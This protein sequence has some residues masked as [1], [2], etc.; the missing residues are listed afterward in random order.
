MSDTS[1]Q[2]LKR[3]FWWLGGA[4]VV[5]RAIG[6]VAS[7]VVLEKFTGVDMGVATVV[8]T[9]MVI[10]ETLSGLGVG[11]H[12]MQARELEEKRV[13]SLFWFATGMG[14]VLA[15]VTVA[16][17]PLLAWVYDQ[18]EL[19]PLLAAASLKLV[20]VGVAL[21]PL[22]LALRTLRF[23]VQSIS[24]T[25]AAFF[26]AGTTIGLALLGYGAWALVW[27]GTVRGAV[28]CATVL[29]I[30]P[31]RVRFAFAWR[32][33][34]E[35]VR[36]GAGLA[37]ASLV[38]FT[39][40]NVER[41]IV[42]AILG[43]GVLGVY[44]AASDFAMVPVSAVLAVVIR[45]G[46]PVLARAAHR[47]GDLVS[48]YYRN[49]QYTLYL[50]GPILV[51]FFFAADPILRVLGEG[52][53]ATGLPWMRVLC[54]AALLRAVSEGFAQLYVA[55]G[56]PDMVLRDNLLRLL[57]VVVLMGGGLLAFGDRLG[58]MVIAIAWVVAQLVG[59]FWQWSFARA[60][61]SIRLADYARTLMRPGAAIAF[62]ATSMALLRWMG[63]FEWT[64]L[65]SAVARVA[66]EV[67]AMAAATLALYLGFVS[68]VLGHRLRDLIPK[69]ASA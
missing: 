22:H 33:I 63:A 49:A 11:S 65:S 59:L 14:V 66:V 17:S 9:A 54:A 26:E 47:S 15:L 12:I 39:S 38:D 32:D 1:A 50:V 5:M 29:M 24:E 55:A 36:F 27:S 41:L 2:D 40:K 6:L 3:G 48:A 56:R 4:S 16:V 30:A 69:G 7:G 35:S 31:V 42:P 61:S 53:W 51:F 45:A 60:V 52:R 44:R 18:P 46:F 25:T 19:V 21:V 64:V 28:L 58:A 62:A 10:V 57:A 20:F 68:V 43:L 67:A 8:W 34:G 37:V 13:L 23:H